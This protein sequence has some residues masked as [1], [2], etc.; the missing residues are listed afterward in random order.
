MPSPPLAVMRRRQQS[1]NQP[2]VGIR[3]RVIDEFVDLVA[4]RRQSDE[5]EARSLDQ[6]Q[7]VRFQPKRQA[8]LLQLR[9]DEEID[10]R[11]NIKIE[12]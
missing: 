9:E 4:R 12:I 3:F 8:T 6:R 10:R 11:T 5:V 7:L 1:V 2:L